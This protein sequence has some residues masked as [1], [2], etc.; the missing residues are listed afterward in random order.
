M[1]NSTTNATNTD[2][3]D[4]TEAQEA[5][6]KLLSDARK[7][8]GLEVA[9]VAR[10]LRIS[11]KYLE[12]IEDGRNSDLPGTAYA[13]GFVRSYAEHLNLDGMEIVR[14]Y[15]DEDK[16]LADKTQLSFP[17]PIPEGGVPGAAVLGLGVVIALV[18]YGVW[19]YNS[20]SDDVV[21]TRIDPVPEDMAAAPEVKEMPKAFVKVETTTP[22]VEDRVEEVI[23]NAAQDTIVV[24]E[25]EKVI[26]EVVK[27]IEATKPVEGAVV[28]T[29]VVETPVEAVETIQAE[30]AKVEAAVETPTVETPVE[31]PVT[32]APAVEKEPVDIGPSR[33]TVRALANSWIQ[34]RDRKV[35]RLL[36]TRLLREG[37]EYEVP[38]RAGLYLMTGNAGALELLVDGKIVPSIGGIG[39]VRRDVELD[40]EKL[41]SGSAVTD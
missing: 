12:A 32:E 10:V 36:F 40:P 25:P 29:P 6:G 37:D 1:N 27:V 7:S 24:A 13:I 39:D 17:K 9:D 41:K 34:V 31:T 33:V 8:Q 30:A 22:S 4:A 21:M 11:Q 38:Y 26:E 2:A 5:V 3:E 20:N 18:A 16:A 19:Y 23:V 14:R 15:K 35:K 28:E